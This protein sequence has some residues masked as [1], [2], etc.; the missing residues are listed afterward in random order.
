MSPGLL[1]YR[2]EV[3]ADA[4][5]VTGRAGLP[6]VLETMRALGLPRVIREHVHIRAHRLALI[7]QALPAG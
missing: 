5:A 3:V 7:V 2:V 1:P 4:A 6:L